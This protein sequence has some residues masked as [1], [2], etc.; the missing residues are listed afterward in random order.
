[1][2]ALYEKSASTDDLAAAID[3]QYGQWTVPHFEKGLMRLWR[4]EPEK[5][6][7][8]LVVLDKKDAKRRYAEAGTKQVIFIAFGGRSAC[9]TR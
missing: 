3:Q 4:V 7:I 8:Q 5:F 9:F 6:S 1:M 2:T